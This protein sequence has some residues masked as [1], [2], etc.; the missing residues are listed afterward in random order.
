MANYN[1]VFAQHRQDNWGDQWNRVYFDTYDKYSAA[2]EAAQKIYDQAVLALSASERA[3]NLSIQENNNTLTNQQLNDSTASLENQLAT[4][5]L[6]L[7]DSTITSPFAGTITDVIATLGTRPTGALF[8]IQD[9]RA[10]EITTSVAE[11]DIP[12]IREGQQVRFTTEATGDDQLTGTI[13]RISPTAIDTD[14]NFELTVR[15]NNPD[16]R[17]RIGMNAKLTIVIDSRPDVY[18]VPYDAI[19]TNAAGET[20]IIGL[21]EDGKTRYEIPVTVGMETDYF[22]EISG[23]SVT[24]G[25]KILNDPEGKNVVTSS[26]PTS[27]FGD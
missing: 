7:A 21:R 26:G 5:E 8:V 10:L 22:V 12:L 16:D 11:Y 15:I 24:D 18:S 9:T 1:L 3:N 23:A 4:A 6:N 19:T 14:G 25:L 13:E 20:V 17:L 2:I 27:P